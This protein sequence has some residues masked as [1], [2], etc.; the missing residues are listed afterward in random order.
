MLLV[1]ASSPA[2]ATTVLAGDINLG[3]AASYGV[4]AGSTVTSTGSTVINGNLG[5]YSGTS[6]TGFSPGLLNGVQNIGNSAAIQAK[7]DLTTAYDQAAGLAPTTVYTAAFDLGGLTLT[8]GV[9]KGNSSLGLTGNL[10]LDAQGISSAAW[11]FQI[12][13]TLTTAS[14]SSI[15]LLNG[16]QASN[17]FWQVGSSATLGTYSTFSGRILALASITMTTGATLDGAALA[18]TGAVTMDSNVINVPAV[19]EPSALSLFAVGLGGLAMM[20]RLRPRRGPRLRSGQVGVK[21][22]RTLRKSEDHKEKS[23]LDGL[24]SESTLLR[25]P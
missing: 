24:A 7:T 4:L 11:V 1:S 22:Q 21:S 25:T 5:L 6:V 12:G 19:P 14:A 23:N 3:T 17:I 15:T 20:L 13:S 8:R 10:V 9:Y 16:A 18:Q 2:V